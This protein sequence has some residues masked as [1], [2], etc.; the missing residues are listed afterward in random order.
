MKAHALLVGSW[1]QTLS[2]MAVLP[3]ADVGFTA[4]V[5]APL[6]ERLQRGTAAKLSAY[7]EP[8]AGNRGP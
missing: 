1:V 6:T 5:S 7:L 4:R 8:A 2:S 3:H